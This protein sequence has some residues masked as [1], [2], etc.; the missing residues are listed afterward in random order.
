MCD[1]TRLFISGNSGAVV[2]LGYKDESDRAKHWANGLYFFIFGSRAEHLLTDGERGYNS[3]RP[4]VGA[5]PRPRRG[6]SVIAF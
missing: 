4:P 3:A 2:K 5:P 1:V 6:S